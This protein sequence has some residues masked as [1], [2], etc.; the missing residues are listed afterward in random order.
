MARRYS[1]YTWTE[2]CAFWGMVVAGLTRFFGEFF[3]SMVK[4]VF[5]GTS[6][7]TFMYQAAHVLSLLGNIALVVAIALPAFQFVR[8]KP[9]G[10]RVFYWIM[11]TLFLISVVF[12]YVF[13]AHLR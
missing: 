9:Q 2:V 1:T 12:G 4:W 8:F 6:G 10:W 5:G 3:K 7:E 11:F 13:E